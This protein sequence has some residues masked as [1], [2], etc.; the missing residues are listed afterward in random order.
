MAIT[1]L[2]RTNDEFDK[3]LSDGLNQTVKHKTELSDSDYPPVY[4]TPY[5]PSPLDGMPGFT[6][7]PAVAIVDNEKVWKI[8]KKEGYKPQKDAVKALNF[9]H[10]P[11]DVFQYALYH[12]GTTDFFIVLMIN[13]R[14][15]S[16]YGYHILDL[17]QEYSLS[18]DLVNRMKA[19]DIIL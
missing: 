10:S 14:K 9:F 15:R 1:E 7:P 5:E 8:L 19:K 18:E 4:G 3:T 17:T 6:K 2:S 16:I 12:F 11:I 13:K